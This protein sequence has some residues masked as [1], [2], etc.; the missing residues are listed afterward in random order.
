[1][2]ALSN[3]KL[4]VACFDTECYEMKTFKL[5]NIDEIDEFE[6]EGVGGTE[7]DCFFDKMKEDH[8][9]PNKLVVFTDGYPWGSWGDYTY[10]DTI[11]VIHGGGYSDRFPEAPFGM[12]IKYESKTK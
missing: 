8:H 5:F 9:V 1:M 11:W 2:L 6:L 10:C 7:F 3:F 12:N 4:K